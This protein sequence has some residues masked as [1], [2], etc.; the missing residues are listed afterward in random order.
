MLNYRKSN[1]DK[2]IL[3]TGDVNQLECINEISNVKDYK[4]YINHC[5]NT[6]FPNEIF[7]TENKRLKTK[8]DKQKLK[9]L[10]HDILETDI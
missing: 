2:I 6:I 1:I 5:I 10:K 3:A 4:T 8:E 7:L 9:D